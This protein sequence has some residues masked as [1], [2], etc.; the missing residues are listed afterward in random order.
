MRLRLTRG[1]GNWGN[2]ISVEREHERR[3]PFEEVWL[4]HMEFEDIT[5][6]SIRPG[7]SIMLDVR[8]VPMR[9][10]KKATRRDR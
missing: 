7:S 9:A 6:I 1:K 8:R 5:G 10:R 3:G 4:C 2:S